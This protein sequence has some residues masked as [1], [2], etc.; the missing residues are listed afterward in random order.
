ML[1][2]VA[3]S[4]KGLNVISVE[5]TPLS[6]SEGE[7]DFTYVYRK[8][9]EITRLLLS[10]GFCHTDSSS[11]TGKDLEIHGLIA[12]NKDIYAYYGDGCVTQYE[13]SYCAI[14]SGMFHAEAYMYATETT[15]MK[16]EDR[17][18]EAVKCAGHFI[19]SVNDKVQ[20]EVL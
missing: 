18:V 13:G 10:D 17:V 7:D 19:T 14:G 5:F 2:G 4:I 12:Y 20:L 9:K 6:K 1:I 16:P 11:T 3:G 8:A 15:K